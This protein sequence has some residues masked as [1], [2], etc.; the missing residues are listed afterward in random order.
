MTDVQSKYYK[1]NRKSE[2]IK[3]LPTTY[4]A[5]SS[6]VRRRNSSDRKPIEY[7]RV[8]EYDYRK[9]QLCGFLSIKAGSTGAWSI[10]GERCLC[11][12]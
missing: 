12:H 3:G 9:Y 5:D 11:T 4:G 1:I 7:Q 10:S 2:H 8:A 6:V